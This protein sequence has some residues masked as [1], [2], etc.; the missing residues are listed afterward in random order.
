M[1]AVLPERP[2]QDSISVL[3]VDDAA[4]IRKLLAIALQADGRFVVVD[5]AADGAQAVEKA[6]LLRPDVVLLDLAMPVMDGLQA[7]PLIRERSP[8]SKVVVLSGF[9]ADRVAEEA[10]AL[11]AVAYLEKGISPKDL[12][13][14][15]MEIVTRA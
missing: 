4:G 2:K 1:L 14:R 6:R 7:L 13:T 8:D 9:A 12:T 3:V 5:E 10:L 11:G 15:L